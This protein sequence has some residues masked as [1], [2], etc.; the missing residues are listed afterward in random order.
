MDNFLGATRQGGDQ[1]K[2]GPRC[3]HDCRWV[4]SRKFDD[5]LKLNSLLLLFE[6][7]LKDCRAKFDGLSLAAQ[8]S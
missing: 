5:R 8:G 3:P 2:V 4:T 1:L 7:F 6:H